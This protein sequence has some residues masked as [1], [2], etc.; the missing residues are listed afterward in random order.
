MTHSELVEIARQWLV[1]QKCTIITTE[2]ASEASEQPDAIGWNGGHSTLVECKV[3]ESDFKA[4]AKKHFRQFPELGMGCARYFLIPKGLVTVEEIPPAWGVL[5]YDGKRVRTVRKSEQHKANSR[6]EIRVLLS[7]LRRIGSTAPQGVSIKC[8][9]MQTGCRTTLTVDSEPETLEQ[10]A[11]L[12]A[13]FTE[14]E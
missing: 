13:V 4:D 2:I 1:R 11:I 6:G 8:Y 7:I 9:T 5:E 10:K 12:D 3:S 14:I